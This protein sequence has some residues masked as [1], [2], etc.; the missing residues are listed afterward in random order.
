MK[1]IKILSIAD[2]PAKQELG[3]QFVKG[4]PQDSGMLFDFHH[5]RIL[6]FWMKNTYIPLDIAFIDKDNKIAKIERMIPMSTRTTN[7][8]SP[9]VTAMEVAAGTFDRLG[10]KPGDVVNIDKENGLFQVA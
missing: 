1:T 4:L 3:L 9:C 10:I 2:T 6:S 7:S 8:G 5:P